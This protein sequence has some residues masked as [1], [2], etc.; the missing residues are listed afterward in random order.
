[1]PQL[2]RGFINTPITQIAAGW[3]H[4]LALSARGDLYAAGHGEW[5]QLGVGKSDIATGFIHI[6]TL[7]PKNIKKVFAGGDHSW[8]LLDEINPEIT[9]YT[10]PSPLPVINSSRT[11]FGL[12]NRIATPSNQPLSPSDSNNPSKFFTSPKSNPMGTP[13][14]AEDKLIFR[15][16]FGTSKEIPSSSECKLI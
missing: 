12:S 9:N 8:I 11:A 15:E 4:S 5:G 16:L 14:K 13:T 2:V 3:H 10:P 6:S 7:G 1:L